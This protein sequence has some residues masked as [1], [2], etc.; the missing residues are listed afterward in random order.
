MKIKLSNQKNTNKIKSLLWFYFKTEDEDELTKVI[1]KFQKSGFPL[2]LS[3]V[4][5]LAFQY[6]ELN[7]IKGFSTKTKK[8]G[9]KWA[10]FYLKCYPEIRVKKAKNLSIARA[11]AANEPNVRKWFDKYKEVCKDL[12]INSPEQI[13]SGDETGVQNVPKEQ[14]VVGATGTPASQT[15]S[16]EQGETSTILSFVNGVGLVCPP[17]VIHKGQHVQQYWTNDAPVGWCIAATTKG[18]ITKHK[19]HEYGIH[20]V[21]FLKT[22]HLLD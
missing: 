7:H 11:M 13:W 1:L 6:A 3:K 17:M 18:Y 5:S 9:C 20:F 21:C 19:F 4:C 10:K 2:I 14:L 16:G 22:H 12:G 8:A 15:V